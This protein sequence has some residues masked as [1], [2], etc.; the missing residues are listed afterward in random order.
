MLHYFC[1]KNPNK[2]VSWLT[3]IHGAGGN[4]SIW[5]QQIRFFK[6][7]YHLLLIDL[8]GHGK[9]ISHKFDEIYTF[10]NVTEDIIQV[11]DKEAIKKSHFVGISLGSILIR[12]IVDSHPER[13]SKLVL[14]GAILNL[15]RRSK[16]LMYLGKIT[17]SILPFI[18]IY[19]FFAHVVLPYKNHRKSRQ[20]F[21]RE[22]KNCLTRSF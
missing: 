3:F 8:R 15:N 20:F 4:S 13:M 17:Q 6:N 19:S 18:W 21:I 11:L 12:K 22:A 7:F 10:E 14:A 5:S 9:S 2:N 16:I 1:F